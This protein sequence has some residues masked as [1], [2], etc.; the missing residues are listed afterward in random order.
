MVEPVELTFSP[1]PVP[2]PDG[3]RFAQDVPYDVHGRFTTFDLFLP[4]ATAP[5]ELVVY[6]HGGGFDG[7]DKTS[8]YKSE[9]DDV[10]KVLQSGAALANVN[11]RLLDDIDTD[12]VLKSLGDSRR[13]LQF[14]RYHH[15]TF[16][17]DPQKVV[18]YGSSA[19]GG[20]ALWLGSHSDMAD[21]SSA[22]PIERV[23]TRLPAVGILGSQS[24]YDVLDWPD[25]VFGDYDLTLDDVTQITTE[26]R[27]LSFYGVGSWDDLDSAAVRDY[28]AEVDMLELLDAGDAAVWI[29]TDGP[30]LRPEDTN[31]L[32]HH[33]YHADAVRQR[34]LDVGLEA[35]ADIQA[36]GLQADEDMFSFFSRMLRE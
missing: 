8:L 35:V 33:P 9:P 12:G 1:P 7:G 34:C 15:E 32:F 11:Y 20:T 17:I 27:V 23:S 26:Q 19:G 16:N 24:T 36:L 5:T 3:A 10:R 25:V 2:V 13:A 30:E 18:A 4:E 14:V 28:R 6:F 22:D 31:R 21:A 29:R